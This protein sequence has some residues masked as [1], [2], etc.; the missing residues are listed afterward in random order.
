MQTGVTVTTAIGNDY[1]LV[2]GQLED[3]ELKI[4]DSVSQGEVI[5]KIAKVSRFYSKEGDNL[6][7]QVR[8]G[9]ETLNPMS[10]LGRVEETEDAAENEAM[11]EEGQLS[12]NVVNEESDAV[13]TVVPEE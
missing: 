9:E 8:C 5:G 11:S 10:L 12:E 3:S 4:G 2:Y 13:E 7:F 6:Y 1:Y